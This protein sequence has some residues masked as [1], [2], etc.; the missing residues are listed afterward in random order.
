MYYDVFVSVEPKKAAVQ[1]AKETLAA[2]TDKKASVD[3]KVAAL[4]AAL[5]VLLDEY[6]EVMAAKQKALDEADKCERKLNLA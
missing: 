6:N 1:A 5:K 3:E 4:N 2:A